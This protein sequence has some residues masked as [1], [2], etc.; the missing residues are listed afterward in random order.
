[1]QDDVLNLW[2]KILKICKQSVDKNEY[3]MYFENVEFDSFFDNT[4]T[5]KCESNYI[6]SEI[7]KYKNKIEVAAEI[8][9]DES[10]DVVFKLEKKEESTYFAYSEKFE[11]VSR[12]NTGLNPKNTL[13][14]F[15]IGDNSK[16][17]FQACAAVVSSVSEQD[18][19]AYNPL[20]IYGSSGLGKTHLM[21]AVGNAILDRRPDKKVF[22]VTSEEYSNEYYKAL[23][24]KR[25][26]EFREAFR[27]LDV[28][29]L[30]DIQFFEKVFGS[31]EGKVQEEFFHTFNKLQEQGKQIILISDRYPK[32][33]KNLS[34]R[35]ETRFVQGFSLEMQRPGYETRMAILKNFIEQKNVDIDKNILEYI[36]DSV[37]SNVR[38]LE[39]V[40]T[41]LIGRSNLL[42]EKITLQQAQDELANRIKTKRNTITAEK[43]IETVSIEY[44]IDISAMKSKK[45]QA[46]IVNARQIAM[47][48]IKEILDI[49]LTTIGSLFGGRDHSTVINSIRKI[50]NRIEDEL[51]FKNEI[52][53]MRERI[54]S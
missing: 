33:I 50:E 48:L 49:N 31:G 7:E 12:K 8:L 44:Q 35:L 30:D 3:N 28:L 22:Y 29:L 6:K 19:P 18:E 5:L 14:K 9:L 34:E 21:Q 52:N 24:E 27:S 16:L 47:Y 32:D 41:T 39:G 10:I 13:E 4:L 25:I 43:V 54:T 20:F 51:E 1:M 17:A 40:L 36:A 11:Y 23:K 15:V 53:R 46:N 38:E 37:S 26:D 42:G 45:K 2:S